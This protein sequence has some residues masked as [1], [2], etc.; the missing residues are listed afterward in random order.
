MTRH[1]IVSFIISL[2]FFHFTSLAQTDV[3]VDPLTGRAQVSIPIW[4]VVHGDLSAPISIV[5]SGGGVK[6]EEKEG[7]VGVSWNLDAGGYVS[8]SVRGLPDDFNGIVNGATDLRKGWLNDN[9]PSHIAA[10]NFTSDN[11]TGICSDEATDFNF[12]SGYAYN[13]DA[14]PDLFQIDAPGLSTNFVF[15][16][17]KLP[18]TIPY[19]DLKF[20][21]IKTGSGEITA[22]HITKNDGVRYVFSSTEMV[23]RQAKLNYNAPEPSLFSTQRQ[24]YK[25]AVRFAEQW[26]LTK[27]VSPAGSEINFAYRSKPNVKSV[28][29]VEVWEGNSST[30]TRLYFVE[31]IKNTSV[32]TTISSDAVRVTFQW[33]DFT[34]LLNQ[35]LV[36]DLINPS[37]KLFNFVY[38]PVKKSG[39]VSSGKTKNFLRTIKEQNSACVSFPSFNFEYVD[40]TY[41]TNGSGTTSLPIDNDKIK[42]DIWGYYNASAVSKKPTVYFYTSKTGSERYRH[43]TIPNV[44]PTTTFNG[45]DRSVN[46]ST[47]MYGALRR[48]TYPTGGSA[49][50]DYQANQYIDPET[51]SVAYGPGVRVSQ[52]T[53]SDNISG[54]PSIIRSYAYLT[55]SNTSSGKLRY[56]PVFAFHRGNTL[57]VSENNLAPEESLMYERVIVSQRGKGST[58]YEYDLPQMYPAVAPATYVKISRFGTSPCPALGEMKPDNFGYPYPPN[59]NYDLEQGL[60]RF[61][62]DR[63]GN[64]NAVSQ[65][66]FV[67]EY[68]PAT[69]TNSSM[70]YG[71]RYEKVDNIF[72][73]G[74]YTIR[75]N[76]AKVLKDEIVRTF[77]RTSTA[78]A[79][80]TT[81]SYTYHASHSMLERTTTSNSNGEILTLKYKYVKDFSGASLSASQPEVLA[82]AQLNST[83]WYMHGLPVETIS[84][85]TRSGVETVTSAGLTLYGSVANPARILPVQRLNF[86][87]GTT[88]SP[89]SLSGS[90]VS[91]QLVRTSYRPYYFVDEYD[92]FGNVLTWHDLKGVKSGSLMGYNASVP[93]AS[94]A[95]AGASNIVF[96]NFESPTGRDLT[97]PA[98]V[99]TSDEA[100]TGRKSL[101]WSS[102]LSQTVVKQGSRYRFAMRVKSS[103]NGTVSISLSGGSNLPSV[104]APF[105]AGNGWQLIEGTIDVS[106]AN[107]TF[108][109]SVSRSTFAYLDD[110]VF[111]PDGA[112]I[113]LATYELLYGKSSQTNT[114][115]Q[116]SITSFDELGRLKEIRDQ[117]KVIRQVNTYQYYTTPYPALA[118]TIGSSTGREVIVGTTVNFTGSAA[119]AQ[120]PSFTWFIDG[121]QISTAQNLTYSFSNLRKYKVR[122]DVTDPLLGAGSSEIEI[123]VVAVGS[124]PASISSVTSSDGQFSYTNC[125]GSSKTF[126]PQLTGNTQGVVVSWYYHAGE[127]SV[128]ENPA[129]WI[130]FLP[131]STTCTFDPKAVF[132]SDQTYSIKA[133]LSNGSIYVINITYTAGQKCY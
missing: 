13:K 87:G 14:E 82:L 24:Q 55:T 50:I 116:S 98:G 40:I 68:L 15:G 105:V 122:L 109:V 124:G 127:G 56:K 10:Y 46:A 100:Y 110:F 107:S 72:L 31:D 131:N 48:I 53:I 52:V 80:A 115:F 59:T 91:Q 16:A 112:E 19:V 43:L 34:G 133:A 58:V 26:K 21:V 60:I 120:S 63:D 25:Q 77:D 108:T 69:G 85:I 73:S 81:T 117:D 49:T 57:I 9:S 64:G 106:N 71:V 92:A 30:I 79:I 74:K 45:A 54:S 95:Y 29:D 83:A 2:S 23:V 42:Q 128:D 121:Q 44:T 11:S 118:P 8:R 28:K 132:G 96:S 101:P 89:A 65:K 125:D 130:I 119:C 66:E 5:H 4:N 51:N 7:T 84:S 47:V 39:D 20:E 86:L 93:V 33:Q 22:F 36:E 38:A 111:F 41:T 67:Y 3:P 129:N 103:S 114:R 78:L 99:A 94:F 32:L 75:V 76:T 18:K 97:V 90:G 88:F 102:T 113:S 123:D 17:D 104:S 61:I 27:I 35:I 70:A 1:A 37:S 62:T 6:V 126:T 12:L